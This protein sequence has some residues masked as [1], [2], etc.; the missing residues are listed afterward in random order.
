MVVVLR[1]SRAERDRARRQDLLF[2]AEQFAPKRL[3]WT[4]AAIGALLARK[5]ERLLAKPLTEQLDGQRLVRRGPRQ[6]EEA[7][8]ALREQRLERERLPLVADDADGSPLTAV[9]DDPVDYA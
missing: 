9:G 8:A 5:P 4:R 6:G 1:S 2:E 7:D 3:E